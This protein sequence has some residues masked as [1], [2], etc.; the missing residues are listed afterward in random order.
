MIKLSSLFDGAGKQ[1]G[2][3]GER[4]G[5]FM[6]AVRIIKEM[7][8]WWCDD[9]PHSDSAEYKMWGNGRAIPCV[10]YVIME[11]CVKVLTRRWLESVM[12]VGV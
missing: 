3:D 4:S 11:G 10:M 2:L 7:P 8:D 6:E 12:G 5:L 1:A 9:I